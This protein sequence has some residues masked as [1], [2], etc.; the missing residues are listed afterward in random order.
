MFINSQNT[1][2][3]KNEIYKNILII[4]MSSLG[5][6]CHALPSLTALRNLS[7]TAKI[8]WVVNKPFADL[9]VGHPLLD[10]VI[11]IDQQ[12]FT[13]GNLQARYR[14][15]RQLKQELRSK[16]FDLVID[17]QGLFKSSVVALMTG[18]STRYGYWE[19]RE[20]SAWVSKG[21][22]GAYAQEHVIQRYLDVIRFLGATVDEPEFVL[23]NIKVQEQEIQEQLDGLDNYVVIAPGTSWASKEWPMDNYVEL[24]SRLLD[25]GRQFVL[26]GGAAD[27]GKSKHITEQIKLNMPNSAR[28][29][30]DL[31]GKTTL[32]QLM[33][34]CKH[35]KLYISGDTGPLHVAV[36]TGVPIIAMYG[37]TRP[38]RTGPYISKNNVNKTVVLMGRVNCSPCRKRTC[39]TM[40]CMKSIS[41]EEVWAAVERLMSNRQ[42]IVELL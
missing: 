16:K 40:E 26:V 1:D 3:N 10:E 20:G 13:K 33:A 39:S 35:A 18:C 23:P 12:A 8:S 4:K 2:D 27:A 17:L 38:D 42:A 6:I 5:D 30:V 7:P 14:Y 19:M 15:Y 22:K 34:V 11:V 9:L 25:A 24:C 37:P 36:T 31:T 41:V 28:Y 29:V 21:I 32:K